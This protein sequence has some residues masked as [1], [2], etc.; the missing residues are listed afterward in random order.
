MALEPAEA[1][2]LLPFVLSLA[3]DFD[4]VGVQTAATNLFTVR[5]LR[6]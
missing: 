1:R 5:P 3:G 2:L 6:P 4:N